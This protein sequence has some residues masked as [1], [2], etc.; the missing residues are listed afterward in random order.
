M[1]ICIHKWEMTNIR[2]GYLVVEGCAQCG[3]RS[4]F[5]STEA[6]APIDEYQEG[7]HFWTYFGSSQA[8]K[9][10]LKC[11]KCEKIVNLNDMLG[12]MLSICEEPG[13]ELA[14]ISKRQGKGIWIYVALCADNTHSSSKCVSDAG[15]K[16]LNEYFNQFIKKP[17]K[18]IMVVPCRKCCNPDRCRGIVLADVGLTEL[19]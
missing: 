5:F 17:G 12:L 2:H 19:Y 3:G 16:A 7:E 15:I 6:I 11:T 13:C 9:F 10:D 1:D 4:S 8:V 18:N 14:G